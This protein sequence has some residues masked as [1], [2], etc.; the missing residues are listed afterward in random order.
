M[1][2]KEKE[3][4]LEPEDYAELGKLLLKKVR[5]EGISIRDAVIF[6]VSAGS[7]LALSSMLASDEL[8]EIQG[9]IWMPGESKPPVSPATKAVLLVDAVVEKASTRAR[10]AK[11]V[12]DFLLKRFKLEKKL[13]CIKLYAPCWLSDVETRDVGDGILLIPAAYAPDV[14]K[15]VPFAANAKAVGGARKLGFADGTKE[16]RWDL[17]HV[18]KEKHEIVLDKLK[19]ELW[20]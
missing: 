3:I 8:G 1:L 12:L 17:E 4:I 18:Y 13:K 15:V 6:P 16:L 20:E 7:V 10:Q 14:A 19:N 9:A 5:Q 11:K 2:L